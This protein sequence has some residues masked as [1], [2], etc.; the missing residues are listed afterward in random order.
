MFFYVPQYKLNSPTIIFFEIFFQY[1][2]SIFRHFTSCCAT[3][4]TITEQ[5]QVGISATIFFEAP[6]EERALSHLELHNEGIT[7]IFYSWQQLPVPHRF[8]NLRSQSKS[9]HFYFSSCSGT[10]AN[11]IIH[12]PLLLRHTLFASVSAH[13]LYRSTGT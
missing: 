7:A 11:L 12:L 1:I 4:P 3:C 8:S 2:K 5:E 13:H 10:H 6:T 9:P